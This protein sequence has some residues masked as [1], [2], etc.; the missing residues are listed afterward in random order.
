MNTFATFMFDAS[1][2][3]GAWRPGDAG[4]MA[5]LIQTG[6]LQF[7]DVAIFIK[8]LLPDQY[9]RIVSDSP[10]LSAAIKP[11]CALHGLIIRSV[12]EDRALTISGC[13]AH[14]YCDIAL[15]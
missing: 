2:E 11:F 14:Y 9:L 7:K 5:V 10:A 12:T 13:F 1:A 8:A 3:R 15:A 4:P 6:P